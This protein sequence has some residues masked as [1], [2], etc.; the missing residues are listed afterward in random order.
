MRQR[1]C[2][3]LTLPAELHRVPAQR[4][5]V[6]AGDLLLA[7]WKLRG[8]WRRA[9]ADVGRDQIAMPNPPALAVVA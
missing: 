6:R 2:I 7:D 5:H 8:A 1:R 3:R 4:A 9:V